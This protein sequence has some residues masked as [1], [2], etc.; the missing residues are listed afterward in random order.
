MKINLEM[1]QRGEFRA[2]A[3]RGHLLDVHGN[4]LRHGE[5]VAESAWSPNLITLGGFAALLNGGTSIGS[6]VGTGN[7]APSE[8]DT[9]LAG[10]RGRYTTQVQ[11]S[12]VVYTTPDVDG[13][14]R[15][16]RIIRATYNPGALGSGAVNIAEAGMAMASSPV[17]TTPLLSRGLLVDAF[18]A[19]TVVSMNA[20]TEYLDV[21]WKHT[22]FIKAE[23]TGTQSLDIL[24][25]PT[26]HDFILRPMLLDPAH[27]Q[28]GI[29]WSAGSAIS[30]SGLAPV[31][32]DTSFGSPNY[33]PRVFDGDIPNALNQIPA[34]NYLQQSSYTI[35]AYVS[36]SKERVFHLNLAPGD[37]NLA[38]H[39]R[40]L[41]L[42]WGSSG[43]MMQVNPRLQKNATPA[44]VLR[45]DFKVAMA[46]K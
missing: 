23:L 5:V 2:V 24:G 3:H 38:A 39:I 10:Y 19:P 42:K 13:Y 27:G 18:G 30:I 36:N 15:I 37:G 43:Y 7:T 12:Y 35:D 40:S 14:Y 22:R 6:V 31:V 32:T 11:Y 33:G 41:S 4:I 46:N 45:L 8:S 1:G 29:W 17:N 16:E 34:G 44:R 25:T 9:L 26:D 20:S 28:H 21:Y